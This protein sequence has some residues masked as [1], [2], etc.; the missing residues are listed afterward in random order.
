MYTTYHQ[1]ETAPDAQPGELCIVL[2]GSESEIAPLTQSLAALGVIVLAYEAK[3]HAEESERVPVLLW[4]GKVDAI[5]FATPSAVQGFA[6]RLKH[7]GGT[8]AMLDNVEVVAAT[9]AVAQ[10]AYDLGMRVSATTSE[11]APIIEVARARLVI[12]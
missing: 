6:R 5:W 3:S 12:A 9:D 11:H 1:T 4:Q 8:L 7:D 2:A 10:A